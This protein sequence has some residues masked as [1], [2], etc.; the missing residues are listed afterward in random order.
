MSLLSRPRLVLLEIAA[1][2]ALVA[3]A[4]KGIW[5]PAGGVVAVV[6]A[7][8][9]LVS[10]RRRGLH[11]VVRS[12]LA[13]RSRRSRLRGQGIASLTGD[14]YEVVSVPTAGGGVPVGAIRD[15]TTWSVPLALPLAGVFNDDA[16]IP[17]E[18]LAT[19]LTVE[20]VPLSSVRLVTMTAPATAGN[21]AGPVAPAPRLAMRHLVLT[22]DTVYAADVIAQRGGHAAIHQILR[23][24]VLRAEEVLASAGVEVRRLTEKV[25]AMDSASCLGPVPMSPDGTLPSA[26]ESLNDVR[27]EGSMSMT[28]AVSG[29]DAV[30]KLD[31]LAAVLPVPIVATS[32]VLQPGPLHRHPTLLLLLRLSGPT[33]VVQG[34]VDHLDSVSRDLGLRI[35]RVLGEQVPLLKATTLLGVS[36]EAA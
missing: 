27:L 1:A 24:C 36:A 26:T 35:N 34:A 15:A 13:M 3:V 30:T 9:A 5:M 2:A 11:Q 22:L 28:F 20:D 17:L 6:A 4:F 31:Q 32:A 19:L 14:S 8:L 16:P 12:W 33:E 10:V 23:R 21:P 7:A 18:R 29:D 25:V